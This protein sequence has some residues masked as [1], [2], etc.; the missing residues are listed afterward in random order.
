MQERRP[1]LV[2]AISV[3]DAFPARTKGSESPVE[4]PVEGPLKR[5]S[6]VASDPRRAPH[7]SFISRFLPLQ[8]RSKNDVPYNR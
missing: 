2:L 6:E 7:A 5:N 1:I 3:Q 8:A 4:R